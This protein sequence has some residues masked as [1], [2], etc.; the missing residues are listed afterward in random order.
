MALNQYVA[1][2]YESCR[3]VAVLHYCIMNSILNLIDTEL[4]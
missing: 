4:T 3:L 2:L 1:V